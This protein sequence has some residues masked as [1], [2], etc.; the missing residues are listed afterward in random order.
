MANCYLCGYPK[1]EYP[2]E[3]SKSFTDHAMARSPNSSKMCERCHS[4][5]RGHLQQL[6][7][8]NEKKQRWSTLWSRNTSWLLK[9]PRKLQN[10]SNRPLLMGSQK[11]KERYLP[12]IQEIPTR[13]Q[14]REWLINP[15][16]PP[17][18]IAVAESGQ[19]HILPFSKEAHAKNKFPVLLEQDLLYVERES[20]SKLLSAYENLMQWFSKAEIDSGN[21]RSDRFGVA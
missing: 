7:Y 13:K 8:W 21:Y 15:P 19:K 17:F 11:I 12:I 20:F 14:I 2:L 10:S 5:I 1:A 6:A 4:L 16:D 9:E 3:L 18:E